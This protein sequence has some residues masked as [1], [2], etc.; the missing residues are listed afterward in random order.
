L[1]E[2]KLHDINKKLK[3]Y[4]CFINEISLVGDSDNPVCLNIHM[5]SNNK[6][7][8]GD[9]D[10]YSGVFARFRKIQKDVEL[11]LL[12]NYFY[13]ARINL[14]LNLQS[15]GSSL[16][17]KYPLPISDYEEMVSEFDIV[18][19]DTQSLL[20]ENVFE[21]VRPS[22]RNV[23]KRKR[24][25]R[26]YLL[27]QSLYLSVSLLQNQFDS[28]IV[29]DIGAG[30]GNLACV[31]LDFLQP[32][33][34]YLHDYS[35]SHMTALLKK[36]NEIYGDSNVVTSSGDC[37]KMP[38]PL[39]A[40][41]VCLS[42]NPDAIVTFLHLRGEELKNILGTEGLVLIFVGDSFYSFTNSLIL[43]KR[44]SLGEWPWYDKVTPITE[45]FQYVVISEY[46]TEILAIG[47]NALNRVEELEK[48]LKEFGIKT[49]IIKRS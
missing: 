3:K 1:S 29:V 8:L 10:I 43:D 16:Y 33:C 4:G 39:E 2:I 34:L 47:S 35:T 9:S 40:D 17:S 48:R 45:L 7:L 30:S 22:I 15:N 26:I 44:Y 37:I 31:S 25:G 20:L 6:Q 27:E 32:S 36:I 21:R 46:K 42:V 49:R 14:L 5:V 12:S 28:P 23:I 38:L 13:G 19:I 11:V 41:I 18:E 24:D